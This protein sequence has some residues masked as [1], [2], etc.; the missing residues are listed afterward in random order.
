M[1]RFTVLLYASFGL[2][3][4]AS[5]L[6]IF[7]VYSFYKEARQARASASPAIGNWVYVLVLLIF[8]I[9]AAISYKVGFLLALADDADKWSV[10]LLSSIV[11]SNIVRQVSIARKVVLRMSNLAH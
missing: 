9:A 8:Q 3:T 5:L 7:R 10:R 1:D 2:S 4:S 11:I 6:R